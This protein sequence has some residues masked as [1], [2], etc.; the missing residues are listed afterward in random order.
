MGEFYPTVSIGTNQIR[1]A[2]RL[3]NGQASCTGLVVSEVAGYMRASISFS[4]IIG[5]A[6]AI[7]TATLSCFIAIGDIG[8]LPPSYSDGEYAQPAPDRRRHYYSTQEALLGPGEGQLVPL[9]STVEFGKNFQPGWNY[10]ISNI[11]ISWT[12]TLYPYTPPS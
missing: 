6:R 7:S 5:Q 8:P 1:S 10:T 3:P 12:V 4:G 11:V 2:G 9:F